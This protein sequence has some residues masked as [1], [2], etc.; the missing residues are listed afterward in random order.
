MVLMVNTLRPLPDGDK[1]AKVLIERARCSRSS[2][3][4]SSENQRRMVW[5]VRLFS[6]L[7]SHRDS[8]HEASSQLS[9]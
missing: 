4:E 2:S 5:F 3:C 1:T 9:S 8:F 7:I 6:F